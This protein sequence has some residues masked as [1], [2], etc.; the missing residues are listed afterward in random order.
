VVTFEGALM[1]GRV[2]AGMLRMMGMPETVAGTID[3]Y[4]ALSVRMANDPLWRKTVR[5]GVAE[6]KYRLYCDRDCIVALE[7]FLDRVVRQPA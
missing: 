1:R 5:D 4:V 2:S 6:N 3:D 7:T